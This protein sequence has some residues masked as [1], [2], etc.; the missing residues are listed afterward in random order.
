VPTRLIRVV[1]DALDVQAQA[2]FWAAA[3]GWP[4]DER[5]LGDSARVGPRNGDPHLLFVSS[6]E[7]KTAKN[8]LHL[9]LAGRPDQAEKVDRLI[10][11]GAAQADI[12]QGQVP[13]Q[14]LAD[15]EGNEFCVL[16]DTDPYTGEGPLAVISLDAAHPAAQGR[17]WAA[18]TGWPVVVQD[19]RAVVLRSVSGTGPAL[20]MGPP[21]APKSGK[22]RLHLDVA[23]V[24]DGDQQREVNRLLEAGASR[25]H[26][27][28][29]GAS[30]EMLA[31]PEGNEFCLLE[32]R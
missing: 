28:H 15:P 1:C 13:W 21:V 32:P 11:L 9:D 16:A 19:E 18:A 22:N 29:R 3:L 26:A 5:P 4:V 2:R 23:P 17:F 31:D 10:G 27:D 14:V 25:V 6:D 12:G 7:P 30:G 24:P 20:M 8:R